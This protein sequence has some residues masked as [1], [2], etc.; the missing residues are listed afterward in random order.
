LEGGDFVVRVGEG[1]TAMD[2]QEITWNLRS[3]SGEVAER[4]R[5]EKATGAEERSGRSG[6]RK[7]AETAQH[8]RILLSSA[9]LFR[10]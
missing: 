4:V 5:V 8:K 1:E 7:G 2:A 3:L 9:N 6:R 10:D